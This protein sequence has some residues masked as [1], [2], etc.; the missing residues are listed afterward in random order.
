MSLRVRVG[1]VFIFRILCVIVWWI[2]LKY[3][4]W[5]LLC[6]RWLI[7]VVLLIVFEVWYIVLFFFNLFFVKL[8]EFNIVVSENYF[9]VWMISWLF[10]ILVM[11][12]DC[13]V[14]GRC[15]FDFDLLLVVIYWFY[16]LEMWIF[17]DFRY[18]WYCNWICMIEFVIVCWFLVPFVPVG[19]YM[20]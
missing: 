20:I 19:W 9:N 17:V 18:V 12:Y 7:I 6:I 4:L 2:Y 8:F 3:V 1:V 5:M 11:R 16:C 13:L 15:F 10:V 14:S